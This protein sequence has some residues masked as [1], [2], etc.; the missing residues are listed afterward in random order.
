[1]AT[2]T[3]KKA[4]DDKIV[5]EAE[6]LVE[7]ETKKS[8]KKE[9]KPVKKTTKKSDNKNQKNTKEKKGLAKYLSEVKSEM[10]KVRW[11]SVKDMRKYTVATLSFILFFALFFLLITAIFAR[12]KAGF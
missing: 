9:V 8:K 6:K 2:V 1:M 12:L 5:K 10:E 7:K 11:P 4:S 3:K